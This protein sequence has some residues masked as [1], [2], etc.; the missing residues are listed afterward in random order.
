MTWEAG[1]LTITLA[2]CEDVFDRL[3]QRWTAEIEHGLPD[4]T[5]WHRLEPF[6]LFPGEL[7][8][9]PGDSESH[10]ACNAQYRG[11]TSVTSRARSQIASWLVSLQP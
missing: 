7:R 3:G 5:R 10:A 11:L 6:D 8:D 9:A 1:G 2:H 4:F